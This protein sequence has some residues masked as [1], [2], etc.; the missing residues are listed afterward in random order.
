[1]HHASW[2][3]GGIKKAQKKKIRLQNT[4]TFAVVILLT[5]VLCLQRQSCETSFV[6]GF[7]DLFQ[8]KYFEAVFKPSIGKILH[9]LI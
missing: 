6:T 7:Q 5:R 4:L 3:G 8:T 1:M 2:W 9:P